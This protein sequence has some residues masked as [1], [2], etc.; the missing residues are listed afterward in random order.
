MSVA[1]ILLNV[2]NQYLKKREIKLILKQITLTQTG[3]KIMKRITGF[4]A[5]CSFTL[6]IIFLFFSGLFAQI[7]WTD[8]SDQPVLDYGA[9]GSWDKFI[10][11]NAAVIKDG[12]TLKMWYTGGSFLSPKKIGYAYSNDGFHWEKHPE[13]VL[14]TGPDGDWDGGRIT[15]ATVVKENETYKMWFQGSNEGF[16]AF[17]TFPIGYAT[18]SDGILWEKYDDPTTPA[19]FAGS[20][21]VLKVGTSGEWD[22]QRAWNPCVLKTENGYEMWYSG[23]RSSRV[24][25]D[26]IGYAVSKDGFNWIK[27]PQNP[28]ISTLPSWGEG[29]YFTTVLKDNKYHAWYSSGKYISSSDDFNARIGYATSLPIYVTY[30]DHVVDDSQGNNNERPDAGEV[31]SIIVTLTNMSYDAKNLSA[32]L[33]TSDPDVQLTQVSANYGDLNRDQSNS[34]QNNPFIFSVSSDAV[35]HYGIFYL[36]VTADGGYAHIDSFKIAIGTPNILLIDDDGGAPYENQYTKL[37]CPGVWDVN[38]KDCPTLDALKQYDALHKYDAAIWFTGNDRDNTLTVEE[39]S[40]ISAF[41]D[42]GGKLLLS[43]QD[44]GH[45]LVGN[46]S[47]SDSSF[48]ANYLHAKFLTDTANTTMII[49][50]SGDPITGGLFA[51]FTGTYGGAGNQTSPDE[52]EAIAPA[53]M[54]LKYIPSM[55][56]AGLKY[57]NSETGAR[58][59]YMPF[60]FEGISGP[61]ED[62]AW[63]LLNNIIN[64]LTQEVPSVV[65]HKLNGLSIP[66]EFQLKQN[67]PNPFNPE[68]TIEYQVPQKSRIKIEIFNLLGQK[69]KTLVDQSHQPGIFKLKWNGTNEFG[70]PVPSGIYFYSLISSGSTQ[71]RKMSLLK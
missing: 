13:P 15:N 63:K 50:V 9:P 10:V 36:N 33:T 21:P 47:L 71:I 52:I 12:D 58:L 43:G 7:E 19:P 49:G 4:F 55:T 26:L 14:L 70:K 35:N 51:N 59:V 54:I 42:D 32:T 68:T 8:V 25:D 40:V 34:N 67:Y 22:T 31:V 17:V 62:S 1:L 29:L 39:Q 41:L 57:E 5:V 69:I 48:F 6:I 24:L 53:E 65:E 66:N 23:I 11:N 30:F 44:I 16:P 27:W 28:I 2:L 45:D 38:L 46:G 61:H 37:Y 3:G 60:G 56:C 64:W 18:S 20:D